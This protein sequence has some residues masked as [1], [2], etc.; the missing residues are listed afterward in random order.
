MIWDISCTIE[1]SWGYNSLIEVSKFIIFVFF[2]VSL[3][4]FANKLIKWDKSSK[5]N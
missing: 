5:L 3:V 2:N 4:F 1:S